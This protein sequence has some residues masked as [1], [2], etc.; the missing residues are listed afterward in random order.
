MAIITKQS[1]GV[2]VSAGT[3]A[4]SFGDSIKEALAS[5]LMISGYTKK[6]HTCDI[7]ELKNFML[8]ERD[9][10]VVYFIPVIPRLYPTG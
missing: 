9:D 3:A 8:N 7:H 5:L 4:S 2:Y 1:R 10:G 6:G